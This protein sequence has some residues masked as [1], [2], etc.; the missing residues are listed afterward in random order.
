MKIATW[1][2]AGVRPGLGARSA[3]I[4][5]A[6]GHIDADV[7]VLTESHPEFA[8]AAECRQVATSAQAPDRGH[9]GCW[10]AIWTRDGIPAEASVAG[11]WVASKYRSC[12]AEPGTQSHGLD[13]GLAGAIPAPDVAIRPSR[14]LRDRR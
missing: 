4:R 9:G 1:N 14:A 2:L 7:W 3:R 8:P 5:E 13:D 11:A 12:G 6:L 10:V